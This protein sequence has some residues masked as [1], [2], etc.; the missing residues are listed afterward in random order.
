MIDSITRKRN[1]S[2]ARAA[3]SDDNWNV[4]ELDQ[5]FNSRELLAGPIRIDSCTVVNDVQK[6]IKTELTIVKVHN[7]QYRY[8]PYFE[9]L[10]QLKIALS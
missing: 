1:F 7:G 4:S 8:R 9:R 3:A 5:F 10:Q 6:F 2:R